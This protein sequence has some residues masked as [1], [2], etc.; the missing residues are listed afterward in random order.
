MIPLLCIAGPTASGKTALAVELAKRFDGEIVSADSMQVYRGIHIASAAPDEAEKQGIRH[1]LIEFLDLNESLTV[2]DYVRLA[3]G[4]IADIH[5]RG[6][7]PIVAGGTGL[8]MDAL[9]KGLRFVEEATDF[10]LR[11]ELTARFDRSG[12]E[13]MLRR[14]AE[15]DPETAQ[16]LHPNDKRRI[17]RA[18]EI[19]ETTGKTLTEANEQSHPEIKKYDTLQI[20]LTCRNRELLYE[21][22]NRRVDL[23]LEK[24][25]LEEAAATLDMPQT[26]GAAQAIGHKELYPCLQGRIS[27]EEAAE[28]LKRATRRYAKRQLTW[29]RRNEQ[30]QWIYTDETPDA[31]ALA[32]THVMKWRERL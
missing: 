10:S 23:M 28:N 18:F 8:Y 32:E 17:I 5:A 4:V 1:H 19:Y 11:D 3:D 15:F 27:Q 12:G 13:E 9:T 2:A 22:I 30:M 26:G 24:G 7:L 6:K 25:L 21:R 16:R 14:L 31:A 20:G 29:F